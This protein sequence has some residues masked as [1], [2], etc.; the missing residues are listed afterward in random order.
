MIVDDKGKYTT[1][2]LS[3]T[4]QE[5][6]VRDR[7]LKNQTFMKEAI[8]ERLK[9]NEVVYTD[10]EVKELCAENQIIQDKEQ[11]TE[12]E[13]LYYDKSVDRYEDYHQEHTKNKS[14]HSPRL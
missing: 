3:G 11:E 4:S 13:M 5:R 7:S 8:S 10:S 14:Q 6:K 2:Q 1:Y 12:I 9:E